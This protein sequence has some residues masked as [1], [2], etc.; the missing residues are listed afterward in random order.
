MGNAVKRMKEVKYAMKIVIRRLDAIKLDEK[1]A[2]VEP[3]Y[4]DLDEK[5]TKI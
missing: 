2:L 1:E 3:L 5:K 4:R